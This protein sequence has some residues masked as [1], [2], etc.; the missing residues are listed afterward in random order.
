MFFIIMWGVSMVGK[1]EKVQLVVYIEKDIYDLLRELAPKIYGRLR[2]SMSYV[3]NEALKKYLRP[4]AHTQTRANRRLSVREV[5][6]LVRQ[7]VMEIM[8]HPA[9]LNQV[10]EEVLDMAIIEIRGSDPRTIEKWKNLF[11]K[12]GLIKFIGGRPPNRIIELI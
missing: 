9:E 5:Y 4:S 8:N 12:F 10:P 7:K 3:V 2:G 11:E 6:H 1:K